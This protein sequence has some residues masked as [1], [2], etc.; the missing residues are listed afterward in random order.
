MTRFDVRAKRLDAAI[1]A[2]LAEKRIVGAVVVVAR[3][4]EI[5]YRRAAGLADRETA[6]PVREDTI[7]RLASVTKP[8][9]AAAAMRLIEQGVAAPDQPIVDL[10]PDFRP[11]LPDGSTPEITVHQLLTHTAGLSYRFLEPPDSAYHALNVSDGLDQPGLSM[12]EKLKRLAAA[13][14]AYPPG[15]RWRYSLAMDVLGAALEKAANEPL[16]EIVARTVTGP[17]NMTDTAYRVVDAARLATPYADGTPEPVRIVD[18]A[19]APLWKGE[20]RFDPSRIFNEASFPSGGG[21]MAGTAGDVMTFL[22]AMRRDG[23]PILK[24]ET[25]ALMRK[26]HVAPRPQINGP[27]WGFG[28]GWALLVDPVAADT[29]QGVGTMQW[30]GAYGHNWFIDPEND[31]CVVAL[32]NTAFEGMVGRWVFDVRNAVY[33]AE[34]GGP[35]RGG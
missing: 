22:E 25:A 34:S 32:T 5:V 23:A 26:V 16:P 4:G 2:A 7:F 8:F 17:L 10:L 20:V 13:P 18:G 29:P 1:D 12:A 19:T 33:G 28:Y 11:R 21:G 27:G 30:G 14:L 9:V 24:P 6:T 15:R 31:L 35:E 3:R